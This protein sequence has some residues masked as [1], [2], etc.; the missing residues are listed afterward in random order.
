M[1][2]RSPS[3]NA[4]AIGPRGGSLGVLPTVLVCAALTVAV[5]YP[6]HMS[7]DTIIQLYEG[8]TGVYLSNQPP[9]MSLL[10]AKLGPAAMLVATV[11]LY[12]AAV[13]ALLSLIPAKTSYRHLAAVVLFLYPVTFAYNGILWKDVL[14]ANLA[15]LGFLLLALARPPRRWL[16]LVV[17]GA[18]LGVA[19]AVRQQGLVA[20]AFA[21]FAAWI[22]VADRP[23][24]GA[25]I[26]CLASWAAGFVAAVSLLAVAVSA[27]ATRVQSVAA[28]GPIYQL[29]LFDLAGIVTA[30]PEIALPPFKRAGVDRVALQRKFSRYTPERVDTLAPVDDGTPDPL[31]GIPF[32]TLAGAWGSAVWDSPGAYLQHRFATMSW[33]LGFH[34]V[35]HCLP[36][37]FGISEEPAAMARE[38]ALGHA[39][40][41]R[42]LMLRE[43][44]GQFLRLYRPFVYASVALVL[45]AWLAWRDRVRHAP[46]ILLQVAG[47]AYV[48]AYLAIGIAC[49]FRYAYFMVVAAIFGLAYAVLDVADG[50]TR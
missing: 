23:G 36:Y 3:G 9:A 15:L 5:H 32:Q 45:V 17:S 19:C 2:E 33:L 39:V 46:I 4:R 50:R 21:A 48:A 44:E 37:H 7:I 30:R 6:G 41:K 18:L 1:T 14:F 13:I 12:A 29:V 49:D 38:L 8:T 11:G 22:A 16:V 42:V 28:T 34:D 24:R 10:L 20:A 40:S 43:L 26:G 31:N 27:T 35:T 25:R 47:L